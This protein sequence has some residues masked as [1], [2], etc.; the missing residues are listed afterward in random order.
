MLVVDPF[1]NESGSLTRS[2]APSTWIEIG[3]EYLD[4]G[5][6][7]S[8]GESQLRLSVE[9]GPTTGTGVLHLEKRIFHKRS[10]RWGWWHDYLLVPTWYDS[11]ARTWRP[12]CPT[13][14]LGEALQEM[15]QPLDFQLVPV[16][17]ARSTKRP[18]GGLLERSSTDRSSLRDKRPRPLPTP[19]PTDPVTSR[20]TSSTSV[21]SSATLPLSSGARKTR[22]TANQAQGT[23]SD[24]PLDTRL[25]IPSGLSDDDTPLVSPYKVSYGP[26]RKPDTVGKPTPSPRRQPP[27]PVPTERGPQP[28]RHRGPRQSSKR[29]WSRHKG[30]GPS[31]MGDEDF[32]SSVGRVVDEAIEEDCDVG[33]SPGGD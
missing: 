13:R 21:A 16:P 23:P 15:N 18:V 24:T 33:S 11:G 19:S 12:G 29:L 32:W 6:Q 7:R 31:A 8:Q 14:G 4:L 1:F 2:G 3:Y 26:A 10:S 27:P 17:A 30:S 5:I 22:S 9:D 20:G 25:D 28:M